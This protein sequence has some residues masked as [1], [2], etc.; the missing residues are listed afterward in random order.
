[1][2]RLACVLAAASVGCGGDDGG[3][4]TPDAA[5][6]SDI[7]TAAVTPS[8]GANSVDLGTVGIDFLAGSTLDFDYRSAAGIVT[9]DG[10]GLTAGPDGA[11]IRGPQ[12]VL[13]VAGA[14]RPDPA[15]RF[16]TVLLQLGPGET[17][18]IAETANDFAHASEEILG[19][20]SVQLIFR[21]DEAA[22][23]SP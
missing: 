3:S 20:A 19:G 15:D 5:G 18:A 22:P 11:F 2:L 9:L 21:F 23:G 1:M 12:V 16:D 17:G 6:G 8:D 14:A 4:V 10:F 13:V 7:S